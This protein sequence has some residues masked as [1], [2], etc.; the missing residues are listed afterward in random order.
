VQTLGWVALGLSHTK[1]IK[2]ADLAIGWVSAAGQATLQ[3]YHSLDGRSVR[4]D[5]SQDVELV[6]GFEVE[7][8][9]VLRFRRKVDTCDSDNDVKI[10]NDTF[11]VIWAYSETDPLDGAIDWTKVERTGVRLLHLYQGDKQTIADVNV[12]QWLVTSNQ[13]TLP[14]KVGCACAIGK[15]V[16][17]FFILFQVLQKQILK[18][19]FKKCQKLF[20]CLVNCHFFVAMDFKSSKNKNTDH[21]CHGKKDYLIQWVLDFLV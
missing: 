5:S 15:F 14:Q 18:L 12:K 20:L 8:T 4:L 17:Y 6:V 2:G 19:S 3:D 7:E 16:L 10:T 9:T 11:R 1:S 21:M 13:M